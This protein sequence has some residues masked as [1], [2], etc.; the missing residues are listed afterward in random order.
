MHVR[1]T[2]LYNDFWYRELSK[3]QKVQLIMILLVS[4]IYLLLRININSSSIFSADDQ[5]AVVTDDKR[6]QKGPEKVDAI[7][8][9]RSEEVMK[10]WILD[11]HHAA[12]NSNP[13]DFDYNSL[14]RPL[15]LFSVP[16]ESIHNIFSFLAKDN[17]LIRPYFNYLYEK[18]ISG[19]SALFNDYSM[20]SKEFQRLII[21]YIK[22]TPL[23]IGNQYHHYHELLWACK[24][25][26]KI[27]RCNIFAN[28]PFSATIAMHL[29][30]NCDLSEVYHLKIYAAHCH[31]NQDY[32][33]FNIAYFDDG[34]P[35]G[36][37]GT[38]LASIASLQSRIANISW[39]MQNLKTLEIVSTKA[40]LDFEM[41]RWFPMIENLSIVFAVKIEN[42]KEILGTNN[43]VDEL[44]EIASEFPFLKRLTLN[45]DYGSDSTGFNIK[46]ETLEEIDLSE[47][48]YLS[49]NECICPRLKVIKC[50]LD[51]VMPHLN[52]Y[53]IT[54]TA[55][56][57]KEQAK[58]LARQNVVTI[59]ARD[60]HHEVF[61][62]QV[63]DHCVLEIHRGLWV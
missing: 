12:P 28:G 33:V 60:H 55:S 9:K 41:V 5:I 49:L 57:V 37:F 45:S 22:E 47:G 26:L 31:Y 17:V 38:E 35:Y 7:T 29:L 19:I 16:K 51:R 44:G 52:L 43:S 4:L 24:N 3:E 42:G 23:A 11:S 34:I 2:D 61:G 1:P 27:G 14:E 10:K 59:N 50:K 18:G 40:E 56:F 58:M 46:S 63:P 48:Y 21:S 20:V 36:S 6:A 62:L 39:R 32:D 53:G 25:K 54:A 30:D 8:E 15:T 13:L